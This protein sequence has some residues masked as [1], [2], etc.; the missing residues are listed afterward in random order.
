MSCEI[1]TT[2][3]STGDVNVSVEI[4]IIRI[5]VNS[6]ICWE[7]KIVY[8]LYIVKLYLSNL[9]KNS[10]LLPITEILVSFILSSKRH[11]LSGAFFWCISCQ[12]LHTPTDLISVITYQF[13]K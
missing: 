6:E 10:V 13:I 8:S 2:V 3:N 1:Q 5:R 9:F 4:K 7:S 12:Y 11:L